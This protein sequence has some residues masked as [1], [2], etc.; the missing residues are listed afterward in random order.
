[1]LYDSL[2]ALAHPSSNSVIRAIESTVIKE[3]KPNPLRRSNLKAAALALKAEAARL[4]E[5][6]IANQD[7]CSSTIMPLREAGYRVGSSGGNWRVDV[8][9]EQIFYA[10]SP[11]R[12]PLNSL[13]ADD[14]NPSGANNTA[15]FLVFDNV[16]ITNVFPSKDRFQ[17]AQ[18]AALS[19][20]IFQAL[21][22]AGAIQT[23]A[24]DA[25]LTAKD[26]SLCI[27]LVSDVNSLNGQDL[28]E[29]AF[30]ILSVYFGNCRKI[31][32]DKL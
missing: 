14:M 28:P 17:K 12:L 18:L 3:R 1:M 26:Q 6:L 31:E 23:S 32:I 27:T 21:L 22:K 13:P 19:A 7:F 29:L 5:E 16:P 9:I 25:V 30:D 24:F 15:L 20:D 2:T 8:G 10:V 4:R 11:D